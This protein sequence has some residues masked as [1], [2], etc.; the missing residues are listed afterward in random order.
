MVKA[1][2]TWRTAR[3]TLAEWGLS[4]IL[5]LM[6]NPASPAGSRRHG[7]WYAQKGDETGH[8]FRYARTEFF[9]GQTENPLG[10]P[11]FARE[12]RFSGYHWTIRTCFDRDCASTG[13][14]IWTGTQ[15]H[16]NERTGSRI[17]G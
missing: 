9:S 4:R 14:S 8:M 7:N 16:S 13:V 6:G 1:E 5:S 12:F 11:G 17:A 15:D 10:L 2:E 3:D